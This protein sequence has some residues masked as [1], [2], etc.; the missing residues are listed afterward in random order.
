MTGTVNKVIL[1]GRLGSDPEIRVSQ[2]G[3]KL[4]KF[5]IATSETWNDK[6]TNEKKKKLNGIEL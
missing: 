3:N 1:I 4:A 5:S 2:D 6:N